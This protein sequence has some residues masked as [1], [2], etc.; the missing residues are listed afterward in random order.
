MKTI[1]FIILLAISIGFVYSDDGVTLFVNSNSDSK[2]ARCGVTT[3]NACSSIPAAYQSFIA[4]GNNNTTALTLQLMD[5]TYD[6]NVNALGAVSLKTLILK[7]NSGANDTVIITN[8]T[9]TAFFDYTNNQQTSTFLS[10]N[11]I[12]FLNSTWVISSKSQLAV[13]IQACTFVNTTTSID[14]PL[15]NL[16]GSVSGPPLPQIMIIDS[17]FKNVNLKTTL[18][19]ASYYFVTVMNANFTNNNANVD[20]VNCT[21]QLKNIVVDTVT[22]SLGSFTFHGG[23]ITARDC[24]WSFCVGGAIM[25]SVPTGAPNGTSVFIGTS[26]FVSNKGQ[27]FM[28]AVLVSNF[29]QVRMIDNVFISNDAGNYVGNVGG[30]VALSGIPDATIGGNNFDYNTNFMGRGGAIYVESTTLN[31]NNNRIQN[32]QA[33][34]GGALLVVNSH[35]EFIGNTLQNNRASNEGPNVECLSSSISISGSTIIYSTTSQGFTCPNSDCQLTGN[36]TVCNRHSSSSSESTSNSQ[37]ESE[38]PDHHHGPKPSAGLI[39]GAI[40]GS[41]VGV[42]IL[43]VIIIVVLRR[44]NKNKHSHEHSPL[45]R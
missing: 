5:G 23:D 3:A 20:L 4:A 42:G 31:L 38:S 11:G 12:V 10:L 21:T 32:S 33:R 30:A 17:L 37:S 40:I 15:F 9:N 22:S 41:L 24:N 1:I 14:Q 7:S 44:G 43:I 25:A 16:T 29:N 6:A 8:T 36:S 13:Q 19:S 2:D 34:F 39:A 28:G 26:F 45:I 18:F 27:Y 35:V